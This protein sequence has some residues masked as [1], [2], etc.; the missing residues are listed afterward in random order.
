MWKAQLEKPDS[1]L[2]QFRIF[3]DATPV[4]FRQALR[5]WQEDSV[6][7]AFF[8][9]LLEESPFTAFRWETPP[10]TA[11]TADRPFE[12]VLLDSP[13]LAR[14]P[15]AKAFERYFDPAG[16]R[17]AVA[18]ANLGKDATLIVPRALAAPAVYVHLASF[19]RAAPE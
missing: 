1:R 3:D 9:S 16:A 4:P 14:Q 6:F 7:R 15:D 19:V 18:F 13:S 5:L 17:S 2:Q 10:V 12:F 8:L 11:A